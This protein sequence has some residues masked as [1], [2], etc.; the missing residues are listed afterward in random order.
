MTP[1]TSP[2]DLRGKGMAESGNLPRQL[3]GCK[4]HFLPLNSNTEANLPELFIANCLFLRPFSVS[5]LYPVA[6]PL[7]GVGSVTPLATGVQSEAG[8]GDGGL[9]SQI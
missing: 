4:Y 3:S 2:P 5:A 7:A 6:L 9:L 1:A 8:S